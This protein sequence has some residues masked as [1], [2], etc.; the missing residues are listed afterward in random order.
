[1]SDRKGQ[2]PEIYGSFTNWKARPM[3]DIRDFCDRIYTDKPDIFKLSQQNRLIADTFKKV[4]ELPEEELNLY[5]N[6]VKFFYDSYKVIWKDIL[7]KYLKYKSPNLINAQYKDL[8]SKIEVPLYV[9]PVF[10]KSGK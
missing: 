4:E 6:E 10:M 2:V 1:M 9:F 7:H 8:I 3:F 5:K